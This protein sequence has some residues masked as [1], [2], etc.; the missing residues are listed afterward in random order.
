MQIESNIK[1]S[2]QSVTDFDTLLRYAES[3]ASVEGKDLYKHV[4]KMGTAAGDLAATATNDFNQPKDRTYDEVAG[5]VLRCVI[6]GLA[7]GMKANDLQEALGREAGRLVHDGVDK[8]V[9]DFLNSANFATPDQI[10]ST[11][12]AGYGH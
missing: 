7:H 4:A 6:F 2:T 12:R 9:H 8:R 3:V 11:T 10:L 5:L 1:V